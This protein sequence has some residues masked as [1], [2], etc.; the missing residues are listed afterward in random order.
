MNRG[1]NKTFEDIK[2]D[3]DQH[4][5]P[6]SDILWTK[7]LLIEQII[8]WLINYENNCSIHVPF[9]NKCAHNLRGFP[10]DPRPLIKSDGSHSLQMK[11]ISSYLTVLNVQQIP[12]L[13]IPVLRAKLPSSVCHTIHRFLMPCNW[14]AHSSTV[15]RESIFHSRN[16]KTQHFA[17]TELMLAYHYIYQC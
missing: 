1:Q 6:F 11:P 9:P 17:L 2:W 10:A 14:S 15:I 12:V 5:S 3:T 7:Q 13:V 4:F 16:T 8:D